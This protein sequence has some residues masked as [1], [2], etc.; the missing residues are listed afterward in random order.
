MSNHAHSDDSPVKSIYYLIAGVTVFSLQDVIIKWMSGKYPVNEIV[1]IRSCFAIIPILFIA[2]LEGGFHLL[3]TKHYWGHIIRS[4]FMFGAYICFYLSMAALPLAET[5]SLFFSAPIFIT[6]LSATFLGEKVE[7]RSWIAVLAGFLGVIVMLRPGSEMIEPAALLAL[8]TALLYAIASIITRKLGKTENGVAMAFY[9]AVM[10]IIF[11]TL[12]TLALNNIAVTSKT[13]PSFTF[14]FREW[15]LPSQGDLFLLMII[16][17]IAASGFYFLAQAYRL[18]Q[19]STIAPF[20]YTAVPLSVVWGY[21]FFR[22]IL[23]FQ[24]IAGMILI[25]GSGLYIF[26]SKKGLTNKYIMS[27]FKTKIRR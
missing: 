20:E 11:A 14:L 24:S 9:V 15:R 1:L 19:P 4:F 8:L 18:A 5:V 17:L 12:F 25:V 22:D 21:L 27:I 23:V 26:G 2:H 7:V 10:Y 16:G 3:R 6:I 13:H